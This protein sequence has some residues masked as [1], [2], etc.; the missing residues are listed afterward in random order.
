MRYILLFSL[1][2][3]SLFA[4]SKHDPLL[5]KYDKRCR[6]M[7]VQHAQI[8]PLKFSGHVDYFNKAVPLFIHQIWFGD[9]SKMPSKVKDWKEYVGLHRYVHRLWNEGDLETLETFMRPA[10]YHYLNVMLKLENYPAASDIVRYE[11]LK[12]FGG[13]YFDC[14]FA[15]P[16]RDHNY[17]NLNQ[18]FNLTGLTVVTEHHGRS[19]GESAIFVCN[20][21][22][23]CPPMH[24]VLVSAVDQLEANI[25]SWHK[26][27]KNYDAMFCTG[28]FFLNKILWGS[29]NVVPITY[30][31]DFGMD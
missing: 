5:P 2:F 9:K 25:K 23:L 12:K 17:V 14:D 6:A 13:I 4:K 15:P 29:F 10:N 27:T 20:G 1:S 30:L 11:L 18:I 22:M 21:I 3:L 8:D 7:K 31:K 16:R 24:P 28:P 19:I 26:A